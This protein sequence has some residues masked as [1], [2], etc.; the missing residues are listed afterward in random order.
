MFKNID[1]GLSKE[2][3]KI[4][5]K[6]RPFDDTTDIRDLLNE[7][8]KIIFEENVRKEAQKEMKKILSSLK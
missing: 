5:N 1:K 4:V 8:D 6:P 2:G 7:N 3:K